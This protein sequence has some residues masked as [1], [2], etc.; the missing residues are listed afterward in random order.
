MV[1]TFTCGS[2]AVMTADAVVRHAA[3]V[4]PCGSPGGCP[5]TVFTTIGACDMADSLALCHRSIVATGAGSHHRIMIHPADNTPG[6]RGVTAFTSLTCFD[7]VGR[8]WGSRDLAA[9]VVTGGTIGGDP[10]EY[11]ANMTFFTFNF[12]MRPGQGKTGL[13]MIELGGP[14]PTFF[15]I[16]CFVG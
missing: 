6:P 7:V 11:T 1:C 5:V 14:V 8:F 2:R 15:V 10:F 12:L 9:L 4:E 3:V 16:R 13:K